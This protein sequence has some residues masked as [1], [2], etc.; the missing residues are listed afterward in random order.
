MKRIHALLAC[1]L[2]L[3]GCATNSKPLAVAPVGPPP[4]SSYDTT[5]K[6]WLQVFT[7]TEAHNDGDV[8][9]YPHTGYRLLTANEQLFKTVRNSIGIHDETPAFVKLPAGTYIVV[10]EGDYYGFVRVPVVIEPGKTT[11]VHLDGDWKGPAGK[12]AE[13]DLVKLPNGEIV[14]WRA[15]AAN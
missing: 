13:A 6:G 5:P 2:A 1:S 15:A 4:L 7:G 11:V 14:G 10:A 8:F 12:A 3:V 9:Y